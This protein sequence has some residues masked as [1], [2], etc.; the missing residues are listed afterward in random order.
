[1]FF[2]VSL[3]SSC[4]PERKFGGHNVLHPLSNSM[5]YLIEFTPN[6]KSSK[7]IKSIKNPKTFQE[8][9]LKSQA[10][11]LVISFVGIQNGLANPVLNNYKNGNDYICQASVDS[12][13]VA[14]TPNRTVVYEFNFPSKFCGMLIGLKGKHIKRLM[15]SAGVNII[16]KKN[17]YDDS[18]QIVSVEGILTLLLPVAGLKFKMSSW[19]FTHKTKLTTV[20]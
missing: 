10:V 11:E 18:Q 20:K 17:L 2:C 9:F 3:V 12:G 8:H 1:M 7:Y 16:V 14:M 15:D 6:I 4:F 19:V 5:Q 13:I